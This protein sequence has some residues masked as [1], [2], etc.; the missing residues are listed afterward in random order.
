MRQRVMAEVVLETI[1]VAQLRITWLF[2]ADRFA[3]H[4]TN[5]WPLPKGTVDDKSVFTFLNAAARHGLLH[6]ASVR[7]RSS[8]SCQ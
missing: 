6:G 2:G 1:Q 7:E 5:F 4:S 3:L 8:G